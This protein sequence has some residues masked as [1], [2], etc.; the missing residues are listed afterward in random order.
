MKT[1]KNK[2]RLPKMA[3]VLSI[4]FAV[5]VS[6][7]GDKTPPNE[8][9]KLSGT[10]N[11]TGT[12][13]LFPII[14]KWA[15]EFNK[16]NPDVHIN[17]EF[18]HKSP[19]INA[20]AAPVTRKDPAKG[21]YTAVSRFALVP[22]INANNPA[23]DDLK[24]KGISKKD[25]L[26]IY[27]GGN[28]G[29]SKNFSFKKN[30]QVPIK[31]Y[32]RGACASATFT[33]KFGKQIKDLNNVG[34]K[35]DDDEVLLEKVKS[36]SLAVAYNNLGF[37]YNLNSRSQKD[38]IRVIPIDLNGNGKIDPEE[39]VYDNLDKLIG[40]I[41]RDNRELPP[42]GDVTFIYKSEKPE[43]EAFVNWI[44]KKGYKFNHEYGFL[45]L[46]NPAK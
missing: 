35:I 28:S 45:T 34:G 39:N 46:P 31:V 38:G 21:E 44:I 11:I 6:S 8:D 16:E 13:F 24:E 14:E 27:F 3:S 18:G 1:K 36:D 7:F 10:I 43:V 30:E 15:E 23:W 5:L 41:E 19:D 4:L 40:F 29:S 20:S 9:T 33:N 17:L 25:F 2:I 42:T 26:E 22:I 12:R 32:S 37:V